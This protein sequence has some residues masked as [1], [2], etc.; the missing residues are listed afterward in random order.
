MTLQRENIIASDV[1]IQGNRNS[2]GWLQPIDTYVSFRVQQLVVLG[3]TN[4]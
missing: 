4:R 2:P 3:R 1:F